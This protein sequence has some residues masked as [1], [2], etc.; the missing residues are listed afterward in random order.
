[1]APAAR[2]MGFVTPPGHE[3][4]VGWRSFAAVMDALERAV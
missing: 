2:A 1:M 4:T 3:A